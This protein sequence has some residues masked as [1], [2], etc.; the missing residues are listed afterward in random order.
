MT[1]VTTG[2]AQ[3]ER[4]LSHILESKGVDFD[5]QVMKMLM[6]FFA[7]AEGG[8]DVHTVDRVGNG[9]LYIRGGGAGSVKV[10]NLLV[11]WRGLFVDGVKAAAKSV[12]GVHDTQI[13]VIAILNFLAKLLWHM[14]LRFDARHAYVIRALA[15]VENGCPSDEEAIENSTNQ[16]LRAENMAEVDRAHLRELLGALS[17]ARVVRCSDSGKW[18]LIESIVYDSN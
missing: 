1:D 17:E 14:H 2:T 3:I 15:S 6:P 18:E 8:A 10:R 5:G 16:F 4:E 13:I 11:N 9:V 7:T 12:G